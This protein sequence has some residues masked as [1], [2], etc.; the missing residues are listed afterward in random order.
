MKN[1]LSFLD[2]ESR[3]LVSS[4]GLL[5][6]E[7]G[8]AA[9]LVGGPVRDLMLK[10]PNT[11]LDIAVEGN[12]IRIADLFA[13]ARRRSHVARYPAFK[14]AAVRLPDRRLV[15]FATARR[16]TYIRSG[17]FP[18]V[19]PADI[20][21]DLFR[22]D[23]TINAMAIAINPENEGK[24]IDP[25]EGVLDL[26]AKRIRIL[27]AKSFLDDPTRILRA[28]RFKARFGFRME[29][30]TLKILKSAIKMKVL[31]T[32]KPQRY[33]KEFNK[34]LKEPKS[35]EIIKCLKLWGAYKDPHVGG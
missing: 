2:P 23:F 24:I 26:R 7:Q 32:I 4:I 8:V 31:E 11:D 27:H 19:R 29:A 14:T 25:Y 9:Y 3:K 17:A 20:K 22:R 34:I 33:L 6:Q 35:L 10:C 5:A 30:D 15:D 21:Q 18:A 28:A 1:L 16:E 12:A 13:A